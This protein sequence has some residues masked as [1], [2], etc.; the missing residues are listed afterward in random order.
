MVSYIYIGRPVS[1]LARIY[2]TE[3]LVQLNDKIV[4]EDGIPY[5]S[6][7]DY[8]IFEREQLAEHLKGKLTMSLR[9]NQDI[10]MGKVDDVKQALRRSNS[11]IINYSARKEYQEQGRSK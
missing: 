4:S 6:I 10:A 5:E 1:H 3:P 2:G 11:L 8:V 9:I 7:K